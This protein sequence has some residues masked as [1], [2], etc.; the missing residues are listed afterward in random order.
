MKFRAITAIFLLCIAYIMAEVVAFA[1]PPIVLTSALPNGA[2]GN[3]YAANI[4]FVGLASVDNIAVEALPPGLSA[5]RVQ[6]NLIK[7][8]GEP[9]SAGTFEIAVRAVNNAGETQLK[10]ALKVNGGVQNTPKLLATG[11]AHACAATAKGVWC[12]GANDDGQLG[13]GTLIAR[14]A[15]LAVVDTRISGSEAQDLSAGTAHTCAVVNNGLTCWGSNRFGQLGVSGASGFVNIIKSGVQ[16]V[17]AGDA[18][19]CAIVDGGVVCWGAN[20]AGQVGI[21]AKQA[22]VPPTNVIPKA[23]GATAIAVGATHSCAVVAGGVRCW[24]S[25]LKG[26][27]G[28]AAVAE[29]LLP[30]EVIAAGSGI[31]AV[32]AGAAHTCAIKPNAV[33]CWGDNSAGQLAMPNSIVNIPIKLETGI[34]AIEQIAMGATHTCVS[35]AANIRCSGSNTFYELGRVTTERNT[36]V[37]AERGLSTIRKIAGGA[38][39]TCA[40][41]GD[42]V[43]CWGVNNSGQ[44]GDALGIGVQ[45]FKAATTFAAPVAAI[46][47]GGNHT[48]ALAGGGLQCWGE[49]VDGQLGDGTKR[50][51]LSATVVFPPNSGVTAVSAG[52]HHTC[53]I[54]EGGLQCWGLNEDGQLGDGS[55]VLRSK[56]VRVF[57]AAAGVTQIALGGFHTCAVLN[58]GLRCWGYNEFGQLGDGSQIAKNQPVQIFP[59]NSGVT[60]VTAGVFHTCIL[61]NGIA[62]CWGRNDDGQLGIGTTDLRTIPTT[63]LADGTTKINQIAAGGYHTCFGSETAVKCS[64]YNFSGQLGIGASNEAFET[65]PKKIVTDFGAVSGIYAGLYHSCLITSQGISCWGA[66]DSGELGNGTDKNALVPL[67]PRS[68]G[69]RIQSV[70]LGFAHTCIAIA[71]TVLCTG[72]NDDGQLGIPENSVLRQSLVTLAARTSSTLQITAPPEQ[73]R[74]GEALV[75]K[76]SGIPSNALGAV[77]LAIANLPAT[78]CSRNPTAAVEFLCTITFTTSGNFAL[79]VNFAGDDLYVP[80]TNMLTGGYTVVAN[81]VGPSHCVF[82]HVFAAINSA[83]AHC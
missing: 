76:V 7:L 75:F 50:A 61:Q 21:V 68:F 25:N 26:Q 73:G 12:W 67:P 18:H 17:A 39:F 55:N 22:S 8:S 52:S 23:S 4:T 44:L 9:T 51:Q 5:T 81:Y 72:A 20:A 57:P 33:L 74:I 40:I 58:G 43:R 53:A 3:I 1:A 15:A 13:D 6:A 45:E 27:I 71:E 70:A 11:R 83:P 37:A 32:I 47:A 77:T 30:I 28:V 69:A 31:T 63:V 49:G 41:V 36:F 80:A 54:V 60:A 62:K 79:S 35:Q 16:G 59:P 42:A 24:G 38:N 66:N 65:N 34:A 48:C 56:P 46:A 14:T 64:G 29:T 2:V 10:L 78:Q 82:A 19:T